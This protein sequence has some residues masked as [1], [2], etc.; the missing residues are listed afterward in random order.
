MKDVPPSY[1][2]ASLRKMVEYLYQREILSSELKS[3]ILSINDA[4]NHAIHQTDVDAASA[5]QVIDA[6][7]LIMNALK[8]FASSPNVRREA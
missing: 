5:S 2:Y 1:R 3:A 4:C 6:S 7:V 8:D